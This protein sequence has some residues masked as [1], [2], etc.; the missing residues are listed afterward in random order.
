M[1]RAAVIGLGGMG[2]GHFNV[3]KRLMAEGYPVEL[4]ALC[5]INEKVFGEKTTTTNLDEFKK[6]NDFN[7]HDFHL[8]TSVDEMLEKENLDFVSVVTPM[9]VLMT[10]SVRYRRTSPT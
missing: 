3:Y 8:Y 1:I 7:F 4:V 6:N 5:D 9:S 2:R 10:F